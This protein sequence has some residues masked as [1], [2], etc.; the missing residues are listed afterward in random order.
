MYRFKFILSVILSCLTVA[1][2]LPS[3]ADYSQYDIYYGDIN[4][5]GVSGDLY[6]HGID[7]YIYPGGGSGQKVPYSI[8]QAD[9]SQYSS[10]QTGDASSISNV[11]TG[12]VIEEGI[13]TVDLRP[14]QTGAPPQMDYWTGPT[15]SVNGTYLLTF[16][17]DNDDIRNTNLPS[18]VYLERK[19][20][21]GAWRLLAQLPWRSSPHRFEFQE[22][23]LA[24]GTYTYRARGCN[25]KG[26]SNDSS[27]K[28]YSVVV[29][30]PLYQPKAPSMFTLVQGQS[31]SGKIILSWV[32]HDPYVAHYELY[33]VAS[34]TNVV[35]L[36]I[37][38][39]TTDGVTNTVPAGGTYSYLIRGC[40]SISVCSSVTT[41]PVP[42]VLTDVKLAYVYDALGRLVGVKQNEAIKEGYLYDKAGNRC[43]VT[44][45]EIDVDQYCP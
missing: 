15:T 34:H 14:F 35:D 41:L 18:S 25:S 7:S 2:C 4:G 30:N 20:D 44:T 36:F 31:N 33:R 38:D 12:S 40:T 17:W 29:S 42:I 19:R 22:T 24:S 11:I 5:D 43:S 32:R 21:N 1:T 3:H 23:G 10:V 9:L 28:W 26:C 39:R 6:F 37:L 27:S 13:G 45:S 8:G 16:K